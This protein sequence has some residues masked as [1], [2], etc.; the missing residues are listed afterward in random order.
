LAFQPF[1]VL[2][3]N[4]LIQESLSSA[5]MAHEARIAA[6]IRPSVN[7]FIACTSLNVK[8]HCSGMRL[9]CPAKLNSG[10]NK[11]LNTVYESCQESHAAKRP[12]ETA[13]HFIQIP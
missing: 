7:V 5:A 12:T 4:M 10:D 3:S 6:A 9:R 8:R 11:V 1:S 13:S 2:P